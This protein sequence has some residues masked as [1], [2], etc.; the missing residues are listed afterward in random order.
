M[1]LL[2]TGL[3]E[4]Q[5]AVPDPRSGHLARAQRIGGPAIIEETSATTIVDDGGSVAVDDW[6]SLVVLV[7]S[8]RTEAS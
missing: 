6:G 8:P 3:S 7:R 4:G 1:Q 5:L 2:V